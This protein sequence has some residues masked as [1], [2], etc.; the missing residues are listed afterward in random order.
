MKIWKAV[1]EIKKFKKTNVFLTGGIFI[2]RQ[3][4]NPSYENYKVFAFCMPSDCLYISTVYISERMEKKSKSTKLLLEY[5]TIRPK[6]HPLVC[7][8]KLQNRKKV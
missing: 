2:Y 1:Q 7:N 8:T 4:V 3:K 6:V 5:F